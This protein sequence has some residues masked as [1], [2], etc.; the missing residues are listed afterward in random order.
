MNTIFKHRQPLNPKTKSKSGV[1]PRWIAA[2]L[3]DLRVDHPAAHD[4]KPA[5]MLA[6]RAPCTFTN[7]TGDIHFRRRLGKGKKM[8]TKPHLDIFTEQAF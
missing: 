4:L 7:I 8:R 5:V 3:K 1:F 2:G 6:H